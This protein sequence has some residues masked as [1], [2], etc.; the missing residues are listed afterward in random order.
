MSEGYSL[1]QHGQTQ[2]IPVTILSSSAYSKHKTNQILKK[3]NKENKTKQAKTME[4]EMMRKVKVH[5]TAFNLVRM[6]LIL[7][8]HIF[9]IGIDPRPSILWTR[10]KPPV[11]DRVVLS[12]N[13]PRPNCHNGY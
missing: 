1:E 6:I 7:L 4:I 12:R 3:E 9:P 10:G 5:S 13:R 11:C 2:V 8:D